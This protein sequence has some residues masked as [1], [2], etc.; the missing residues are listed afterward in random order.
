MRFSDMRQIH[1]WAILAL[2]FFSFTTIE[3]PK[4]LIIRKWKLAEESLTVAAKQRID[5]VR[6]VNPEKAKNFEENFEAVVDMLR[7]A[8]Y[9]FKA[10]GTYVVKLSMNSETA[11]WKLEADGKTMLVKSE[12]SGEK[13]KTIVSLTKDKM[14]VKDET[15][16]APELAYVPAK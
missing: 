3:D 2:L 4:K 13:R 5:N 11:R 9:E 6:K 1:I 12:K 7:S 14:V 15:L 10:D 16:D 8:T